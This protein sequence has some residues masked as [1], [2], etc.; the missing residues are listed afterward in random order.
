MWLSR[1]LQ[2]LL[3]LSLMAF[4]M[5]AATEQSGGPAH[6]ATRATSFDLDNGMQVVVIPDHRAPV[7]THMV[8]YRVGAA[9]EAPGQ[10][11]VAHFLEHLMFKATETLPAGEFSKIVARMG[12]QDNAFT[13][14]DVTAYFQRIARD[15]LPEVMKLEAERMTKLRL[16]EKEVL[17]ERD[18]I[19][20]ERRSRVENSPNAILGEQINAALYLSHPY[21]SPIIGWMHE[22]EKLSREQAIAFYKRFYAPN[23]AI[24]V[25][26][27][28]ITADDARSLAQSTYGKIPTNPDL[29]VPDRPSEPEMRAAR[30]VELKDPRAGQ[31]MFQ[32]H[33]QAPSYTTAKPGEA[34]ALDLFMKVVASGATSRLYR[35]LVTKQKIAASAGGGYSGHSRDYGKIVVYAIP[36]EG[37]TLVEVEDAI[38]KVLA[39]VSANGITEAELER[40]KKVYLA[41]YIYESDSQS[42]LARRYGY[43]LVVGQ[44]IEDIEQWPERIAKVTLDDVKVVSRRHFDIRKSVTGLLKPEKP[45]NNNVPSGDGGTSASGEQA[46]HR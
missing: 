19:L 32:R 13:G 38:D 18:V 37:H 6:A 29:R 44:S 12:G 7:V 36:A 40:A 42:A 4:M 34:E 30:R 43:G 24:L 20:E 5:L 2:R 11:G 3:T 8:W 28:D 35:E 17:T 1:S 46:A 9:D 15:R 27:G 41:D 26:A 45:D 16:E 31:P 23:N 21:G 39:D 25:V 22:V 33:Y 14:Q 10:S